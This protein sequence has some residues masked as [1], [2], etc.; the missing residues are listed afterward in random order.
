MR[1]PTARTLDRHAGLSP[2]GLVTAC[3][4][5]CCGRGAALP[6]LRAV[7]FVA[8]SGRPRWARWLR[9]R[10]LLVW[11]CAGPPRGGG[12]GLLWVGALT[13]S[14]C[15]CLVSFS[16]FCASLPVCRL[17]CL[18]HAHFS[19]CF[20]CPCSPPLVWPC[21]GATPGGTPGLLWVVALMPNRQV[22][23][24]TPVFLALRFENTPPLDLRSFAC[25]QHALLVAC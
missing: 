20:P 16:L 18:Q 12:P 24:L 19:C 7:G 14:C 15:P 13:L 21:A 11:G 17:P 9:F 25:M 6:P 4:P 10:F 22:P 23:V 2:A 3:G 5:P 8:R 1:Q